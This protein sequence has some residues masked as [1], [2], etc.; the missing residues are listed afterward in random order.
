MLMSNIPSFPDAHK[1][2]DCYGRQQF[3]PSIT[4]LF[5]GRLRTMKARC[6]ICLQCRQV[7]DFPKAVPDSVLV[8]KHDVL[9]F[10]PISSHCSRMYAHTETC[11][12]VKVQKGAVK[13]Y[14]KK[15]LF[16]W[17]LSVAKVVFLNRLIITHISVMITRISSI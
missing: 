15:C 8:T 12:N 4:D 10:Y 14:P 17:V 3:K 11:S 2:S 16:L 5:H 9:S 6:F 1:H 13:C 7:K